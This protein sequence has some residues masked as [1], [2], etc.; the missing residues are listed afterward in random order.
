MLCILKSSFPPAV[1]G[2]L[3]RLPPGNGGVPVPGRR[4]GA[5]VRPVRAGAL[6]AAGHQGGQ[7]G[8]HA[9]V[10]YFAKTIDIN[11]FYD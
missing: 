4:G 2:I 1:G 3:P 9:L 11:N 10:F 8:V 6:G 5:A 7:S